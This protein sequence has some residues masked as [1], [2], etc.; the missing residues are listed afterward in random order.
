MQTMDTKEV[1]QT[2]AKYLKLYNGFTKENIILT[3]VELKIIFSVKAGENGGLLLK[4]E[5]W[6][7]LNETRN[8]LQEV[9]A[10]SIEWRGWGMFLLSV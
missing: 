10:A 1:V 7:Q 2:A 8:L 4:F 6:D 3:L 9:G 5:E